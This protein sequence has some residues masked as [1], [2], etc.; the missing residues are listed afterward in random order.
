MSRPTRNTIKFRQLSVMVVAAAVAITAMPEAGGGVKVR[1]R[2]SELRQVNIAESVDYGATRVKRG[3]ATSSSCTCNA[4][5]FFLRQFP[6]AHAPKHSVVLVHD[7]VPF[8]PGFPFCPNHHE[9]CA[10]LELK[11]NVLLIFLTLT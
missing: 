7:F 10:H 9:L 2:I 11:G 1:V 4:L 5:D 6:G 3:A 8:Q